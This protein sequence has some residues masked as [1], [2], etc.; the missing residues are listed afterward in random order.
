V[1]LTFYNTVQEQPLFLSALPRSNF[2]YAVLINPY[3]VGS[4]PSG[5]QGLLQFTKFTALT[6]SGIPFLH[7]K[8]NWDFSSLKVQNCEFGTFASAGM[9]P[10]TNTVTSF[11]NSLFVRSRV[12]FQPWKGANMSFTNN[13]F[14]GSAGV[15]F[16]AI[17]ST[18]SA[19]NNVFDSTAVSGN[20]V[21]GGVL[22]NNFNAYLKCTGT[23]PLG[24]AGPNYVIQTNSLAWQTGPLGDFYQ[25]TNSVLLDAGSTNASVVGLYHYTTTTNQLKEAASIVDLGYHYAA[26]DANGSPVDSDGDGIPD[27]LE[28]ANGNGIY[29]PGID[30]GDWQSV[31]TDSDGRIDEYFKVTILA[32]R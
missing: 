12:T 13:L 2:N 1:Q 21:L 5:A 23:V 19:V 8:A 15:S 27:Y 25:P 14:W 7:T 24:N 11:C 18:I 16:S 26:L 30:V 6:G 28:D 3:H 29:T 10:G 22:S 20:G 9:S 31:D 17:Q 4:F 32:P